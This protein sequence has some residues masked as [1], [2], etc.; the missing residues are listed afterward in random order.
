MPLTILRFL[1]ALPPGASSLRFLLALP[2]GSLCSSKQ[3]PG[4]CQRCL[5]CELQDQCTAPWCPRREHNRSCHRWKG[6][7]VSSTTVK[8]ACSKSLRSIDLFS[9]EGDCVYTD[10]MLGAIAEWWGTVPV[11]G[12]TSSTRPASLVQTFFQT[13]TSSWEHHNAFITVVTTS[14][15]ALPS[16]S[17][18]AF[19]CQWLAAAASALV[20]SHGLQ[21]SWAIKILAFRLGCQRRLLQFYPIESD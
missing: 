15:M 1:L 11:S 9:D 17:S 16:S 2:P 13:E 5:L 14:S 18:S 4:G 12:S 19:C 7:Y 6:L 21:T 20:I 8:V 3:H 10:D